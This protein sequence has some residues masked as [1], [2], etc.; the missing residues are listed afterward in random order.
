MLIPFSKLMK[1]YNLKISGILHVGA[2]E[3]EELKQYTSFNIEPRNIYWIEA[4]ENKVS[5]MKSKGVL[6]I[7]QA[8]IDDKDNKEITFNISNNGQSSS[9]L[10]FGTHSKNY[11]Q[12]KFIDT[13]K[14]KTKRL[15]TLIDE[16][17]IPIE[18]INFVN[19]DIQGIELRALK[20]ME[21]YLCH[22][23]Y[24]YTEVNSEY[25]YKDCNLI[26][27]IDDYLKNFDF[28]RV[29]TKMASNVGWGDA[30]YIKKLDK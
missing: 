26:S 30:F 14:G 13:I 12:V 10:N 6:N 21:K 17:S 7:Y 9:L 1:S 2:H 28:V 4:M 15:D 5:M 25:V 3:C 22:I 8:F 20:S 27:E 18:H 16:N 19:L 24:I 29:E 11:P 23:D